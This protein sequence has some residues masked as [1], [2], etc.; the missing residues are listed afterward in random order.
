MT[1]TG[2]IRTPCKQTTDRVYTQYITEKTRSKVN[3]TDSLAVYQEAKRTALS[4]PN[5]T[6]ALS[7]RTP[8]STIPSAVASWMR[9]RRRVFG[10][11]ESC[12][13]DVLRQNADERVVL[14][15]CCQDDYCPKHDGNV[16]CCW[17]ALPL[18][19]DGKVWNRCWDDIPR[20]ECVCD[21]PDPLVGV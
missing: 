20:C 15:H 18:S 7:L 12:H 6:S 13:R 14:F 4:G 11:N 10:W 9:N 8:E 17:D 3:E 16:C 5:R 21:L 2:R 1:I 19:G